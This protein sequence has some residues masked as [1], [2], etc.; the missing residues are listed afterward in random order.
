[1]PAGK[2][3]SYAEC[4]REEVLHCRY[5]WLKLSPL[6]LRILTRSVSKNVSTSASL[7]CSLPAMH[8]LPKKKGK[9]AIV[10]VCIENTGKF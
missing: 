9:Y 10:E 6:P 3:C 4:A 1:M 2:N 8:F 7:F 5:L